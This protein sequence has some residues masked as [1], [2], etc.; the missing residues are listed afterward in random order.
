MCNLTM[1]KRCPNDA[2]TTHNEA[3]TTINAVS[4][5]TDG[6][7][8]PRGVRE[9]NCNFRDSTRSGIIDVREKE[10][11]NGQE[12]NGQDRKRTPWRGQ[13]RLKSFGLVHR[14][15]TRAPLLRWELSSDGYCPS[16]ILAGLPLRE[17]R[18]LGFPPC[19]FRVPQR[20]LTGLTD[21]RGS[22]DDPALARSLPS[23]LGR[24]SLPSLD[25]PETGAATAI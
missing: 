3:Q 25:G 6:V 8:K 4:G 14:V 16:S 24:A 2:Q 1:Y 5:P 9:T 21:A 23:T 12:K 18:D 17:F 7:R 11:K 13:H 15:P 10:Q 22:T 20:G 19:A